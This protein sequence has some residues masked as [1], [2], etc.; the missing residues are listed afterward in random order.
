MKPTSYIIQ[1]IKSFY[2]NSYIMYVFKSSN[3]SSN[4]SQTKNQFRHSKNV[5]KIILID[6]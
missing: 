2:I 3:L 1:L 4:I 6:L 5:K